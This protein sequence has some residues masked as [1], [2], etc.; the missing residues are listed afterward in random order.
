MDKDKEIYHSFEERR[1]EAHKRA[2]RR[3]ALIFVIG[4]VG[5]IAI[6]FFL[7]YQYRE[8]REGRLVPPPEVGKPTD[9][10]QSQAYIPPV[11]LSE[12]MPASSSEASSEPASEPSSEEASA[13]S[14][15]VDVSP[16][17]GSRQG[18]ADTGDFVQK[19]GG[20]GENHNEAAGVYAY[21]V[22]AIKEA[23]FE[24]KPLAGDHKIAFLTFDDG[25][26]SESTGELLDILAKEGVPATFFLCGKSMSPKTKTAMERM[27]AEG[28]A[29]AFHSFSHDYGYL[30]PGKSGNTKHIMEEYE[31]CQATLNEVMGRK[32]DVKVWRYPG[33]HMSW[34]NLE[35]A[36][37]A[38]AQKGVHWIDWNA[39]NGDA[40]F[41]GAPANPKAQV[42]E[43]IKGWEAYGKPNCMTVLMHDTPVKEVTRQSIPLIVETLRKEGFS[44]GIME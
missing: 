27:M 35:G 26:S 34:K 6:G 13:E 19:A 18:K 17:E 39:V 41:K 21:S 40:R 32:I 36:D 15:D 33:G 14:S 22:Q 11:G 1:A 44:F 29:L 7:G 25:P 23:M 24:G 9:P 28:H 42:E 16:A 10:P 2:R 4:V 8:V 37:K 5:A 38:L 31:K 30:Y 3:R 20:K 12:E 43:L